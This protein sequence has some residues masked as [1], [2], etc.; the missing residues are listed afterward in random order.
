MIT[1]V[2]EWLSS[3]AYQR[4]RQ[5]EC[6]AV[7][8]YHYRLALDDMRRNGIRREAEAGTVIDGTATRTKPQPRLT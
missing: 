7:A 4:A 2:M 1:G 5:A 6:E 3:A 8:D